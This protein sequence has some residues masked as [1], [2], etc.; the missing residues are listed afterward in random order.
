MRNDQVNPGLVTKSL[1]NEDIKL[2]YNIYRSPKAQDG[3]EE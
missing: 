1:V 2:I 3:V